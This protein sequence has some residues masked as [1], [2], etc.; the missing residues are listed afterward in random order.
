MKVLSLFDGKYLVC[1]DGTILSNTSHS[2]GKPIQGKVSSRTGY[3]MV[4]LYDESGKRHYKNVHRLVAELF[5]PN[6]E[7]KPQV[8]HKNGIKTD[9]RV[10][11]LEWST[12]TENVLH[13]RD[14]V[15]SAKC[16]INAQQAGEIR[17]MRK[18]GHS[19]QEITEKYGIKRS[20]I[21]AICNGE[22]WARNYGN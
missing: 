12:P 11:N 17:E 7:N 10:E 4:L 6:P 15:G 19:C 8:N 2:K 9:N 22:R 1:E 3:R 18:G 16:K 14:F 5:I 21:Y 20:Q 13:C